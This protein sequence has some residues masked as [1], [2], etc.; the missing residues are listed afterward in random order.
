MSD[1]ELDCGARETGRRVDRGRGSLPGIRGGWDGKCGGKPVWFPF[2]HVWFPFAHV[3]LRSAQL[4]FSPAR[5]WWRAAQPGFRLRGSGY[6][7]R[8]LVSSRAALVFLHT[9]LVPVC[10]AWF[11]SEQSGGRLRGRGFP[12]M[13]KRIRRDSPPPHCWR[14]SASSTSCVEILRI[15]FM[16]SGV[17]S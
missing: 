8:S 13:R 12:D 4:G 1:S 6:G 5:L 16:D 11:R 9:T 10:A 17:G 3:W 2:A 14:F 7:L 15:S